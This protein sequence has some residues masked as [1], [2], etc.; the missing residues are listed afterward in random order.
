MHIDWDNTMV[1][2]ISGIKTDMLSGAK[3]SIFTNNCLTHITDDHF[4]INLV[5]RLLN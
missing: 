5:T 4:E 3:V 1:T 2:G